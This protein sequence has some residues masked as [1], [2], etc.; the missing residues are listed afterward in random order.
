MKQSQARGKW[1]FLSVLA[2]VAGGLGA[3]AIWAFGIRGEDG[4]PSE[5]PAAPL[6]QSERESLERFHRLATT[7]DVEFPAADIDLTCEEVTAIVET[8]PFSPYDTSAYAGFGEAHRW[9]PLPNT[10]HWAAASDLEA[11]TW[12]GRVLRQT[13]L[14]SIVEPRDGADDYSSAVAGCYEAL[15]PALRAAT[16]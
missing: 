4:G 2:L 13:S 15:F 3:L 9:S 11:L 14:R 8:T 1:I 16:A 12:V 10:A 5:G 6:S 7:E